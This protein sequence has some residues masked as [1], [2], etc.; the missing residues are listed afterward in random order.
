MGKQLEFTEDEQ[1][2]IP[3]LISRIAEILDR[4]KKEGVYAPALSGTMSVEN[5]DLELE[6]SFEYRE[7][8]E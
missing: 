6:F 4:K 7:K 2:E 3:E 8:Q 5:E 1:K